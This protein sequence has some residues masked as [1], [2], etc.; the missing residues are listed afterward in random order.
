MEGLRL[1]SKELSSRQTNILRVTSRDLLYFV[2]IVLVIGRWY[3]TSF[4]IFMVFFLLVFE[5]ISFNK[6]KLKITH[7]TYWVLNFVWGLYI[8]TISPKIW[9]GFVYSVG[10]YV[11]YDAIA[12]FLGLYVT[13]FILLNI[14]SNID[15]DEE[16]LKKFFISFNISGI[17]LS[18]FSIFDFISSGFNT[19]LRIRGFWIDV[20]IIAGYYMILFLFN[21][22][23]LVNRPKDKFFIFYL[24]STLL[25]ALGLFLT[26]TRSAWLAVILSILVF[27][28]KKPKIIVPSFLIISLF[29]VLFFNVIKLKFFSVKNFSSDYSTLGRFQAWY[30]TYLMLK[31]NYMT[32]YGFDAFLY[33]KDNF[34]SGFL[35][36]LPHSHNTFLR[37]LLE[38]G[39][40]GS[41]LYFFLFFKALFI[42]FSFRIKSNLIF[43]KKYFDGFQLIFISLPVVFLFEPYFSLYSNGAI[44]IWIFISLSICLKEAYS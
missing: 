4:Y 31:E 25:F 22:S 42:S 15:I 5:K 3:I 17:I 23:F 32:G 11:S 39:L 10:D 36:F 41:V 26:K 14:L 27:F 28:I 6:L 24:L 29:I 43:L 13:P 44:I 16:F 19:A 12:Y 9:N 30:A 34:Y 21:L 1:S 37:G 40:I 18:L 35:L 33:N 38:L 20:N 7:I 8:I 2:P